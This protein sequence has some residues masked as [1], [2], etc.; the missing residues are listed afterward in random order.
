MRS[1]YI[2]SSEFL[3]VKESSVVVKVEFDIKEIVVDIIR[4]ENMLKQLARKIAQNEKLEGE[5]G[6]N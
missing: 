3:E 6:W 1:K 2:K 4:Y 5:K